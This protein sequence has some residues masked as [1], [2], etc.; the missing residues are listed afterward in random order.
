MT[1]WHLYLLQNQ[2]G[3]LYAGISTAPERRLR[4]HNGDIKGGA[5]A[6]RGKGPFQIRYQFQC[7]DKSHALS[8]EYQLKQQPRQQKCPW[9]EALLQGAMAQTVT[10]PQAPI[11]DCVLAP[12][13]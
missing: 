6:L 13:E 10:T 12:T 1:V 5:K 9:F 8:L 2:A 3:M 4:Q 7:T 11:A